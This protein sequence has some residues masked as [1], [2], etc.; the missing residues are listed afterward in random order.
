M[1][2]SLCLRHLAQWLPPRSRRV[3]PFVTPFDCPPCR[4]RRRACASWRSASAAPPPAPRSRCSRCV[5]LVLRLALR[6]GMIRRQEALHKSSRPGMAGGPRGRCSSAKVVEALQMRLV[7]LTRDVHSRI[8]GHLHAIHHGVLELGDRRIQTSA[9]AAR[10]G[11]HARCGC[12]STVQL[13]GIR[14]LLPG[15]RLPR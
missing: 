4:A 15:R 7:G 2:A 9:I 6:R 12:R 13:R 11:Q 1:P 5:P 8:G 3:A 14:R 10:V